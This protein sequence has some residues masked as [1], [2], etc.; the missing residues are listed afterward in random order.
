[1][2]AIDKKRDADIEKWDACTCI[3]GYAGSRTT[4]NDAGH[5][6]VAG[7][8][9]KGETPKAIKKVYVPDTDF[10]VVV[11]R[12]QLFDAA[13]IDNVRKVQAQY[14]SQPLCAFLGTPPPPAA[15]AGNC[16]KPL[17]KDEHKT[18]LEFFSIMNFV[19]GYSP[20]GPSEAA[21]RERF[22]K[23]GVGGGKTLDPA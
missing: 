21:L 22:A 17:T 11:L 8:S 18:S 10:G 16:I 4:G 2:P 3:I 6:M 15:P 1:M 14:K 5:F 13:D 7:P 9:W 20:T 19:R 23:I 12:T